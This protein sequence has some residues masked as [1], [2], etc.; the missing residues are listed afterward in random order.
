MADADTYM[1][2]PDCLNLEGVANEVGLGKFYT[3]VYRPLSCDAAHP[4]VES[5]R[6]HLQ[7]LEGGGQKLIFKPHSVDLVPTLQLAAD[8]LLTCF[9]AAA[10]AFGNADMQTFTDSWNKRHHDLQSNPTTRQGI[11]T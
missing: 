7:P 5:M 11:G 1:Q 8:A 10:E 3:F 4:T 6:R 2:K 9:E